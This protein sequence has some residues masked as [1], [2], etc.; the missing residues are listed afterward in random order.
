VFHAWFVAVSMESI[1]TTTVSRALS[2]DGACKE[3]A[4]EGVSITRPRGPMKNATTVIAFIE[5]PDGYKVELIER[6]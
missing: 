4:A 5:D 1:L 3:M 6:K 2:I